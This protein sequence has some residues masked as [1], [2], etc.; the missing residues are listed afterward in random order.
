[1]K[2]KIFMV[3]MAVCCLTAASLGQ[4]K[5]DKSLAKVE[6]SYTQGSYQVA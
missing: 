3:L 5:W 1:M 2:I 4:S 6:A